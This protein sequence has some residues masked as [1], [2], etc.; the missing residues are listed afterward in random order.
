MSSNRPASAPEAKSGETPGTGQRRAPSLLQRLLSQPAARWKSGAAALAAI[1]AA[2]IGTMN[3]M[4][5]C[6]AARI[7]D[8]QR[9]VR[10]AGEVPPEERA[11]L[12]L[13]TAVERLH[14]SGASLPNDLRNFQLAGARLEGVNLVGAHAS[15]IRLGEAVLVDANFSDATLRHSDFRGANL[16]GA[17]FSR[18]DVYGSD[19]QEAEFRSR[20]TGP[21]TLPFGMACADFSDLD[22]SRLDVSERIFIFGSVAGARFD[23]ADL[24]GTSFMYTDVTGADFSEATGIGEAFQFADACVRAARLPSLPD[25]VAW[26]GKSCNQFESQRR[27]ECPVP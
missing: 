7:E 13:R 27:T 16:G 10:E 11:M 6:A 14:N 26:N 25:G 23:G 12:P 24:G 5:S 15:R 21:A 3:Q 8:A 18:A 4:E 22:L 2:A 19:F 1:V 17:D 20:G 9:Q